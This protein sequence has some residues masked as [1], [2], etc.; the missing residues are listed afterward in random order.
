MWDG[1]THGPERLEHH[2]HRH[3]KG[4]CRP[5]RLPDLAARHRRHPT[6]RRTSGELARQRGR[7]DA[8][9]RSG[10]RTPSTPARRSSWAPGSRSSTTPPK[11][12]AESSPSGASTS[13]RPDRFPTAASKEPER[14]TR[15]PP[16]SSF[17]GFR[18]RRTS[19]H[20][21]TR[22]GAPS[23]ISWRTLAQQGNGYGTEARHWRPRIRVRLAP[24]PHLPL[25][26]VH[27][28]QQ[29]GRSV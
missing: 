22:G 23:T 5:A 2:Q 9:S 7:V 18:S 1:L 4:R 17:P 19:E 27:H 21:H 6:G 15:L 20:L 28:E 3:R 24:R 13:R 14:S 16:P 25:T 8:S 11:P 10:P 26:I 12:S 29:V